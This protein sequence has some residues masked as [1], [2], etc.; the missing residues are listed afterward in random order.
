LDDLPPTC[1]R[2][3][4][5]AARRTTAQPANSGAPPANPELITPLT[6]ANCGDTMGNTVADMAR[7]SLAALLERNHVQM[8]SPYFTAL[9]PRTQI[10]E[11][12]RS[13]P[14]DS[15]AAPLYD[16]RPRLVQRV[17]GGGAPWVGV[18]D[19]RHNRLWQS[20]WRRVAGAPTERCCRGTIGPRRFSS[21]PRLAANPELRTQNPER[22]TPALPANPER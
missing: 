9:R 15:C 11:P 3:T 8:V 22:C 16:N 13:A 12:R 21:P 4:Q 17:A 5:H 18:D 19:V 2:S 14:V 20:K 6:R 7:L 10:A 1:E